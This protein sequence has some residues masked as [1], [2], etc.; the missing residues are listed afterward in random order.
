MT[1][2]NNRFAV[3]FEATTFR[4]HLFV[5]RI[6]EK[7]DFA[8]DFVSRQRFQFIKIFDDDYFGFNPLRRCRHASAKGAQNNLLRRVRRLS[9]KLNQRCCLFTAH[10]MGHH[11]FLELHVAAERFQFAC[12]VLNCFCRLRRS[13]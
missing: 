5:E 6:I 8:R 9:R 10:P 7:H 3:S 4:G 1:A 13:T 2:I 12:D 11:H